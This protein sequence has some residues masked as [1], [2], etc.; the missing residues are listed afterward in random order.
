MLWGQ[1]IACAAIVLSIVV[2][3]AAGELVGVVMPD[4]VD[5]AGRT[6]VLNGLALRKVVF[7]KVY[8]GG[9]YL[10]RPE[11][12]PTRVLGADSERRVVLH[13]LRDVGR[14]DLNKAWMEGLAANSPEAGDQ[15][16]ADFGTLCAWMSDMAEGDELAVTYVPGGGTT[17][18]VRGLERG[19]IP[20]KGF[21]DAL[22]ACW[23]GPKP[24]PG[25]GFRKAMLGG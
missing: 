15:V 4:S 9:L 24:G 21:A 13:F 20:G 25:E 22:F 14:D 6:L 16:R 12:D 7:F 23:I 19:S 5:V 3:S 1:V 2:P 11:S 10:P 8:V 17:I 18:T